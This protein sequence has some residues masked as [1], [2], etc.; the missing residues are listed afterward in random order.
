MTRYRSSRTTPG[1]KPPGEPVESASRP[2]GEDPEPEGRC[3]G[4]EVGA[5]ASVGICVAVEKGISRRCVAI[6]E[7]EERA[8]PHAEQNWLSGETGARHAGQRGDSAF[9]PLIARNRTAA[10]RPLNP[11]TLPRTGEEGNFLRIL[12]YC[13]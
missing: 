3:L 6:C 4:A 10:G 8:S 9:T 7:T 13:G 12:S 5:G 1:V 2:I 11:F